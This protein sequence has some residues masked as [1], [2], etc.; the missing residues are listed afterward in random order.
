MNRADNGVLFPGGNTYGALASERNCTFLREHS[1]GITIERDEE[2]CV[3]E[4]ERE[5]IPDCVIDIMR[6]LTGCVGHGR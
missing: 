6:N 1:L 5:V 2:M 3:I 4:K